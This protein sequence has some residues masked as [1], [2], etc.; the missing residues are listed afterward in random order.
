MTNAQVETHAP[1]SEVTSSSTKSGLSKR[2]RDI[3]AGV[4]ITLIGLAV[5]IF[6]L[7]PF[8]YMVTTSLKSLEQMQNPRILPE[9]PATIEFDGKELEVY[10]VPM[11]D[12]SM[13]ELALFKPGRESSLF[14]DPNN[15]SAEPIE[16]EGRWRQLD[17]AYHLDFQWQNYPEAWK[18]VEFPLLVRNTFLIALFGII[19]TALSSTLVAYGFARFPIPYKNT[20]FLI[21]ISTIVLPRQVTLIPTYIIF[22]RLGWVGTWLPL[23]VPHFFAN[24]YNVFLLRQYFLTVPKEMDEAAY[25]D[26]ANPL[27]VLWSVI[28]PQSWPVIIAV[29]ISHLIFAW[30][31]YFEPLI[32]LRARPDLQ[33]ISVGIQE[34]NFLYST[35]PELLQATSL[36]ALIIPVV[37]FF[38]AQKYFMQGIVFTGVD[39]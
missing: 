11:P 21:L 3:L 28:L 14:V 32:Y 35:R 24:A 2:S 33:P 9:S 25:I 31:D 7:I 30:N 13:Q 10:E 4:V 20:L 16:W 38:L 22:S 37:A 27:R 6:W 36:L 1:S 19:G 39:K 5:L 12:G 29:S 17:P 8:A 26:G 34:F 23:I 15:L 18:A